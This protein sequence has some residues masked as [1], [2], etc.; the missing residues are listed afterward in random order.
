MITDFGIFDEPAIEWEYKDTSKKES[1]NSNAY[2]KAYVPLKN[3]TGWFNINQVIDD[4]VK[5]SGLKNKWSQ[6]DKIINMYGTGMHMDMNSWRMVKTSDVIRR[7]VYKALWL[8][9]GKKLM[10][11]AQRSHENYL[12]GLWWPNW[13]NNT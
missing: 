12:D 11:K 7:W 3:E 1:D 13:V 10:S 4:I 9:W 5:N 2:V 6:L 8:Q